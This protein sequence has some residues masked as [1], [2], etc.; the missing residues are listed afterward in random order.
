LATA[1]DPDRHHEWV[2]TWREAVQ[3]SPVAVGL[4]ELATHRFIELSPGGAALL[5]TT[6]E[7][8]VGLDYL[9][10]VEPRQEAAYTN[11]LAREGR[12]D[13]LEARRRFKRPDGSVIEVRSSGR[14]IRSRTGPPLALWVAGDVVS[15]SETEQET[16]TD[17]LV[18]QTRAGRPAIPRP[19]GDRLTG[20]ILDEHWRVAH[21]SS[22]TRQL[23]GQSPAELIGKSMMELTH[24]DDATTLLLS[25]ARATT[26]MNATVQL[27]LR[28]RSGTWQ[29]VRAVVTVV[30]PK[31]TAARFGFRFTEI[32]DSGAASR[33]R[34][35]QLEH[36]LRRIAAG[37]QAA[38]VWGASGASLDVVRLPAVGEL[39]NRQWEV[40]S[41]LMRGERVPAIANEM[42]VSQSTIRN[43]LAAI[44]RKMGVHS[45]AEL[46]LLLRHTN[47]P[48]TEA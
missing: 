16:V 8:G 28:H 4:I 32:D 29:G 24:P 36:H 30:E 14:V 39:S 18:A 11:R 3:A 46:L 40:L 38:D 45:Q 2:A 15:E 6:P 37:I 7:K 42:S 22:D 1:A 48:P 27:R 33:V 13:G 35:E 31:G 26:E 44:F 10:I 17:D 47:D 5:G 9:K 25:F 19:D 21:I 20:A 12:L 43:H 41:R 34:I 23:L